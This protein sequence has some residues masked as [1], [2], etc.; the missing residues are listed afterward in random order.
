MYVYIYIYLRYRLIF[1]YRQAQCLLSLSSRCP[2]Q[3][4]K[5]PARCSCVVVQV[6]RSTLGRYRL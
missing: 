6:M 3:G 5:Q 1:F 2:P 4:G